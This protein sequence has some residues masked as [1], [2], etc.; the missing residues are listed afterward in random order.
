MS[1]QN[2]QSVTSCIGAS[3]STGPGWRRRS[4][5]VVIAKREKMNRMEGCKG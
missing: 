2:A 3:A 5:S 1:F 4:R